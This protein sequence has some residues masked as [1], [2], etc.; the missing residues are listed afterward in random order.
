MTRTR[1]VALALATLFVSSFGVHAADMG[2]PIYKEPP[3]EYIVP[4]FNWTGFYVGL[5][6]G[7][8]WA[9]SQWS[10]PANFEVSPN[11]WMVGGT[12]GYNLQAGSVVFGVEGDIDYMDLN[13]TAD[14]AVC[15]GCLTKDTWLAT[16]RGRV[17]YAFDRWLPYITGGGAWGNVYLSTPVGSVENT[18]GGWTAGAGIEYAFAEQWSAKLEYLY[19]DLGS[20]TCGVASCGLATDEAVSFKANLIRAGL[21]FRF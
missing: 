21:N 18:K 10:G 8:G 1:E 19:V 16:L 2:R 4:I 6:G 15:T 20:A 12:A 5:N 14:S 13:G 17:G 3:P 11:G 7:Y 9:S